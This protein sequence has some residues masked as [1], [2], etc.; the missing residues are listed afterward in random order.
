MEETLVQVHLER[1]TPRARYAVEQVFRR[2]L[3]WEVEFLDAHAASSSSGSPTIV[4]GD[5]AIPGTL[6][7]LPSGFLADG[8]MATDPPMIR[9]GDLPLL[10]PVEGGD[11]AFDPFAA[12]FFHL[13]RCEEAA[14]GR[15]RHQR[16][17]SQQ[18]HAVKHGYVERPVVDEW[19]IMLAR[20][21]KAKDRSVPAPQR[22][23]RSVQTIDLDN[24]LKYLGRPLW[25]SIGA[26]VKDM[27]K[28]RP[29]EILARWRTLF[30]LGDDP[31]DIHEDL[32]DML[33]ANTDRIIYFILGAPKGPW[34]HAVSI[35]QPRYARML[36]ELSKWA[37]T[38]IHPSYGSSENRLML[39]QELKELQGL[40][41]RPLKLS[42]Q[43][44]LRMVDHRIYRDLSELGIMEEHSM[45]MHDTIGFRAGTTVPFEWYDLEQERATSLLIHPFAVMDNT[46]WVKLGL[47]PGEAIRRTE[48]IIQSV[49]AVD[50]TFTGLWHESFLSTETAMR[51]RRN[52]ILT[53]IEKARR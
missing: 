21:W 45:G 8:S 47:D 26:T 25:R 24:G 46:L 12:A 52:A 3:G 7:I 15:D 30:S 14:I 27:L 9:A 16:P 37:E 23:Y 43:H 34:D 17:L 33:M 50:G 44:F 6:H 35:H 31:Y 10:F 36:I 4:Y 11:L 42:R 49:K 19:A 2:L 28:G 22:A 1:P 29:G 20:A 53:I 40:L 51:D 48:K 32:K 18:M 41:D 39:E 38:G 13:S 5:R